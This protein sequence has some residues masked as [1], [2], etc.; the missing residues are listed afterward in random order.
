MTNGPPKPRAKGVPTGASF[1]DPY[2]TFSDDRERRHALVSRDVRI[3]GC[4]LVGVVGA[5]TVAVLAPPGS[6]AG[7]VSLLGRLLLRS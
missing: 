5:V 3:F 4:C 7:I 2:C 1:H 6:A